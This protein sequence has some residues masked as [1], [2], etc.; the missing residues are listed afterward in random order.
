MDSRQVSAQ[1][2]F[3]PTT[4]IRILQ[5]SNPGAE[6][7]TEVGMPKKGITRS[8]AGEEKLQDNAKKGTGLLEEVNYAMADVHT[9]L[10]V[11][12]R[13]LSTRRMLKKGHH[14]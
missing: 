9:Y 12:H 5:G 1:S 8:I 4:L 13:L 14:K 10:L 7:D 2:S 11:F 3:C 6:K